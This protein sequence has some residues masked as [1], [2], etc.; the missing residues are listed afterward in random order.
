LH[1]FFAR[2]KTHIGLM[3]GITNECIFTGIKRLFPYSLFHPYQNL[4]FLRLLI[5][6]LLM[7][8]FLSLIFIAMFIPPPLLKNGA[9]HEQQY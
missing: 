2:G 6:K 1:A 9:S 4:N 5:T 7:L 3:L 8:A